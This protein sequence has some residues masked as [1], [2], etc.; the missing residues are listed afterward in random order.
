MA[1]DRALETDVIPKA[2]RSEIGK[3][4]QL[5]AAC[6]SEDAARRMVFLLSSDDPHDISICSVWYD[7][8]HIPSERLKAEGWFDRFCEK[9][10]NFE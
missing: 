5:V 3:T 10:R 9:S 6:E 1:N 7:Y 4:G 8:G 2:V